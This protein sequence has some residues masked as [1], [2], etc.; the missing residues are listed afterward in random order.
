MEV[1]VTIEKN[2]STPT[3]KRF[4]LRNPSFLLCLCQILPGSSP[5]SYQSLIE[6][7]G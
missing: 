1:T 5:S 2:V 7:N 4:V 3:K 6:E